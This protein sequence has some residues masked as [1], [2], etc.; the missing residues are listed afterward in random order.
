MLA[1]PVDTARLAAGVREAARVLA[2][3]P[4]A[5]PALADLDL[6]AQCSSYNHATGTCRMGT[7][8]DERGR[9]LGVDGLWVADASVIPRIV[10]AP[11]NLTT[12]MLAERIA[13]GV[14]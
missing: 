13:G 6:R 4:F 12:V 11:T 10:R 5:G 3:M 8:V 1:E 2:A 7:V 9:V 14:G